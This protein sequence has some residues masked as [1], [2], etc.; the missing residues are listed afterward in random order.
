LTQNGCQSNSTETKGGFFYKVCRLFWDSG[1]IAYV[2]FLCEKK[3]DLPLVQ[4]TFWLIFLGG[5]LWLS[6]AVGIA[7]F[8]L[9]SNDPEIIRRMHAHF[10]DLL[11]I[12]AFL[13]GFCL[14]ALV[15]F[16]QSTA[17]WKRSKRVAQMA[18]MV[19]ELHVMSLI[20]WLGVL[21][22]ALFLWVWGNPRHMSNYW[23]LRTH[24]VLVWL[25][26]YGCFQI[27]A[28]V[29]EIVA[30]VHYREV[31]QDTKKTCYE[32]CPSDQERPKDNTAEQLDKNQH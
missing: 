16:A 18:E 22:F 4:R 12:T 8:W 9:I 26:S 7:A 13:F 30:I 29:F 10:G 5:D 1:F 25:F 17:S 21:G 20:T 15:F 11:K 27:I 6:A 28:Q 32:K 19:V 3:P 24:A 23:L 14:T 31:V 2:R